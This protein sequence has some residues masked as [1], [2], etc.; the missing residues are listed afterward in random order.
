MA[1]LD[2]SIVN[3]DSNVSPMVLAGILGVNV[4][5]L[6]QN[7]QAGIFTKDL[8]L[9][10]Y[11]EAIQTY[12]A[13]YKKSTELK[14]LKAEAEIELKK[15]KLEEDLAIREE[16][17]KFKME[18]EGRKGKRT[19]EGEDGVDGMHPLMA[20]KLTQGIK[21]DR[22]REEQLWLKIA[23]DRKDYIDVEEIVD[24]AE[25]FLMTLRNIL[26]D[27]ALTTPEL[28][29]KID[30]AMETIYALGVTLVE[31]ADL[32]SKNYVQDMLARGIDE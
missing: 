22:V 6:Y 16:K 28:E 32:D 15:T 8:T 9:Y 13:Y 2:N 7:M 19:Y 18:E 23:I 3:L 24:L 20:A 12:I 25:P 1:D 11:R 26:I 17:R 5:L 27:I 30:Q 10:T 4:S 29:K 31:D 21:L 14:V